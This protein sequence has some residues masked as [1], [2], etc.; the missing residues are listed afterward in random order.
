[1][2]L[3]SILNQNSKA[4]CF[5]NDTKA[6][7]SQSASFDMSKPITVYMLDEQCIYSSTGQNG[8]SVHVMYEENSTAEDPIVRIFGNS[9]SGEY[10]KIVHIND[11]D[12]TNASYSELCA[13]L[14]HKAR[15][16]E[17]TP[18]KGTLLSPL[19]IGIDRG[20]YSQKLNY[21]QMVNDYVSSNQQHG[22]LWLAS[23]G[24]DLLDFYNQHLAEQSQKSL[25]HQKTS[26]ESLCI[27]Y[28]GKL[29]VGTL[30]LNESI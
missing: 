18:E 23:S 21:V 11:I 22:H 25:E 2:N 13:L 6:Q 27:D 4:L 20:D 26:L 7:K 16:G 30:E 28:L 1:M 5:G 10:E 19:P 14:A 9:L 15:T 24:E 3:N 17:Y 29:R 12:P 8:Q